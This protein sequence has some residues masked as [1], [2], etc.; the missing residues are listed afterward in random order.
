MC[1]TL[2][3]RS[4]K[5]NAKHRIIMHKVQGMFIRSHDTA[6]VP[7]MHPK[8]LQPWCCAMQK[9]TMSAPT[10]SQTWLTN[11]AHSLQLY[12]NKTGSTD[13]KTCVLFYD[14]SKLAP[15]DLQTALQMSPQHT[16]ATTHKLSTRLTQPHTAL[17]APAHLNH[18]HFQAGINHTA[19][20]ACLPAC[21]P[22][23]QPRLRLPAHPHF[24]NFTAYELLHDCVT[25]CRAAPRAYAA[26]GIMD[27]RLSMTKRKC[28]S[29]ASMRLNAS[30]V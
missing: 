2:H 27:F 13:A 15:I 6:G 12:A 21:L 29:P 1:L 3:S 11:M 25:A 30:F 5:R 20:R 18:A 19:S 17:Q 4:P 24:A 26:S 7:A 14:W 16:A 8:L 23:R 28:T 10:R 22:A 9:L